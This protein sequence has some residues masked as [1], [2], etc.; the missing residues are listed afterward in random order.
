MTGIDMTPLGLFMA[1]GPVGKGVMAGLVVVSIWTWVVVVEVWL[2]TRALRRAVARGVEAP[3]LAPLTVTGRSEADL[4]IE[5]ESPAERRGRI[6]EAMMRE[7]QSVVAAV[8]RGLPTLAMI[9]SAAPFVGLF[10]TVWGIMSSFMG[11]AAAQDTSLAVV[12]PGI[13][14]ALAA[15]AVGLA[16]AIPASLGYNRLA[17]SL[18]RVGQGLHHLVERE[19]AA[20]AL[21]A[22]T[23]RKLSGDRP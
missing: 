18:G 7:A 15:T 21:T 20:L 10:G 22:F 12:A 23:T 2:G 9:A 3:L 11:I 14:E 1:A 19:A 17:A 13:A 16:A 8:E 6:G 5:A 4:V